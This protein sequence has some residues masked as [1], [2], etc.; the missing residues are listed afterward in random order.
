[1]MIAPL[2]DTADGLLEY[3][4]C[5][6]IARIGLIRSLH[7]LYDGSHLKHPMASRRAARRIE[8]DLDGPV[9]VMVDGEVLTLQCQTLEVLSAALDVLV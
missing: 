4:R 8:F 5:G 7:T 2:A 6:P 9:D 1:M 3:V